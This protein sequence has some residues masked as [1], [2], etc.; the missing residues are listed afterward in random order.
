MFETIFIFMVTFS[1]LVG[2]T[3]GIVVPVA[4]KTVEVTTEVVEQAIDY[5]TTEE[6]KE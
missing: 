1:T 6:P 3:K 5:V 2:I 4:E